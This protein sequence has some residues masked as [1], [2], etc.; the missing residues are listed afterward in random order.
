MQND[1][2]LSIEADS[3]SVVIRLNIL[4]NYLSLVVGS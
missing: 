2:N 3:S 4:F 1:A